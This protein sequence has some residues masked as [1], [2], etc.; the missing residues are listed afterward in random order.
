VTHYF[1]DFFETLVIFFKLYRNGTNNRATF[2]HGSSY[3]LIFTKNGL[4]Y[5]LG[6]S[7]LGALVAALVW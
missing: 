4:G 1:S 3:A 2:Y 6:D 5:I 7:A